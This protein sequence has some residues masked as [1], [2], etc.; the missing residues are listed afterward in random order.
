MKKIVLFLA[1]CLS[2]IMPAKAQWDRI[3]TSIALSSVIGLAR[4]SI[5]S[6]ERKKA[7]EIH[8]QQKVQFEQDFK[9]SM[10]EA[11]DYELAEEW[12]EA[13]NKYEEA[14]KLN[15]QYGYSDQR[16]IT[17]KINELYIKAGQEEDGPSILNNA[18]TILPD[19]SQYRYVRENPVYVN[20]KQTKT[21]IV[22]VACSDKETRLEL[23][24]EASAMDD[25]ISGIDPYAGF[26][27]IFI[28]RPDDFGLVS[29]KRQQ[30]PQRDETF[31]S[32][33]AVGNV[34]IHPKHQRVGLNK[35]L[36]ILGLLYVVQQFVD[37]CQR[38]VDPLMDG[39]IQLLYCFQG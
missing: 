26:S 27:I 2:V 20:K 22:R 4:E 37:Y 12:E 1:V 39:R 5:E 19:Y 7:M 29:R 34:D 14:A 11:K 23:E 13:L 31:I 32:R 16:Q 38:D 28:Q 30:R 3:H 18:K 25:G 9:D 15:C 6:A 17:K 33:G 24:Y 36:D 21:K 10:T 8:A 35:P